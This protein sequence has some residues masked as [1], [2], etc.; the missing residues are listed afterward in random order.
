MTFLVDIRSSSHQLKEKKVRRLHAFQ[1]QAESCSNRR[2]ERL[3]LESSANSGYHFPGLGPEIS[4]K[5]ARQSSTHNGFTP[6]KAGG[7]K[8]KEAEVNRNPA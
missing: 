5:V 6:N 7:N 1:E 8:R 3:S 2:A 4:E